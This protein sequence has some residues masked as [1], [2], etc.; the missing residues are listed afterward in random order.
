MIAAILI[1]TSLTCLTAVFLSAAL[2]QGRPALVGFGVIFSLL[3]LCRPAI[4]FAGLDVPFPQSH[5]GNTEWSLVTLGLLAA[6][7][8]LG[9]ASLSYVFFSPLAGLFKKILPAEPVPERGLRPRFLWLVVFPPFLFCALGTLMLIA[10]YG[11]V[12][13][14]VYA[15]KIS[16]EL[17]GLF[18]FQAA[19]PLAG[20]LATYA[21]LRCMR[22]HNGQRKLTPQ[23]YLY[24]AVFVA[25]AGL[26][27]TWGNRYN[28]AIMLMT[29]MFAWH[30]Y[31]RPLKIRQVVF[32]VL[33]SGAI[34]QGLSVLRSY[35]IVA[36]INERTAVNPH[37]FWLSLSLSL[38]FVEFDAFMLALR[39]GGDLFELRRGKD[40]V[41]GL[42]A[43]V[44]RSI[45]PEKES[46]HIGRWFAQVYHPWLKNGWPVTTAGAWY[47][48][49]GSTGLVMGGIVSGFILRVF[50]SA[51]HDLRTS[52]WHAAIG[53]GLVF[54][55][56]ETGV[57]TGFVQAII[58]Y[59]VPTFLASGV[60]RL[61]NRNTHHLRVPN[62]A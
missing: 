58:L 20:M 48:N 19:A 34:L 29:F 11:G 23:S 10:K 27:F 39:D 17:K 3:F 12:S 54:L 30:F 35:L 16:K 42:L 9:V 24:L 15:S 43:W 26:N 33:L 4:F 40:F 5:F 60:L 13:G 25:S 18:V 14:F 28:I 41:N 31:V 49:F 53:L 44:P 50:D 38:H 57:N 21:A 6:C 46:F 2:R 62:A 45:Y 8:W 55:C 52:A 7:L 37:E 59:A 61:L 56:L 51:Y 22:D 47:V 32:A 1:W 36:S